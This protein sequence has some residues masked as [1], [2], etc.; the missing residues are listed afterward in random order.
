MT[1]AASAFE[2]MVQIWFMWL[3]LNYYY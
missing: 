2:V 3:S 1:R